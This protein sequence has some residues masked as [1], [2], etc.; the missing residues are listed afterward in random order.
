MDD[1]IKRIR[2]L[3]TLLLNVTPSKLLEESNEQG[4]FSYFNN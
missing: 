4:M 1:D 3:E 2:K